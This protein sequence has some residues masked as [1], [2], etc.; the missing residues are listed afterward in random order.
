M[1]TFKLAAL[2]LFALFALSACGGGGGGP[3]APAVKTVVTGVASKGLI[4]NGTVKIYA[5][6][7]GVKGALLASVSTDA[8]GNYTLSLN[9]PY[10]AQ[11]GKYTVE[12]ITARNGEVTG[13]T[14]AAV[15][16]EMTG[17]VGKISKM[18]SQQRAI[19]GIIAIVVALTVGFAVGNIFK[20]GGGAH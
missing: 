5:L 20:K 16:V 3:A 12:V 8:N 19:Y 13:K 7:N 15:T 18:A 11:P 6:A 4:V 14:E 1:K 17:F 9:W 10:Q 2:S